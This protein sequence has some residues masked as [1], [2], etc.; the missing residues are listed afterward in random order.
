MSA[1]PIGLRQARVHERGER[2][3]SVPFGPVPD[4]AGQGIC[5]E[6]AHVGT[7]RVLVDNR[8]ALRDLPA[9]LHVDKDDVQELLLL[10]GARLAHEVDIALEDAA[11][12][13]PSVQLAPNLSVLLSQRKCRVEVPGLGVLPGRN[14]GEE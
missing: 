10:N 14:R 6:M 13:W 8:P 11:E 12:L 4:R 1:I 2:R 7:E 9:D 5:K 3:A